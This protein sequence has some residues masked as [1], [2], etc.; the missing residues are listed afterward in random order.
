[1]VDNPSNT[2]TERAA[3]NREYS[4]KHRAKRF[5]ERVELKV[6]ITNISL[7]AFYSYFLQGIEAGSIAKVFQGTNLYRINQEF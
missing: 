3:R 7:P 1:M 6:R 2:G 4:K 5:G